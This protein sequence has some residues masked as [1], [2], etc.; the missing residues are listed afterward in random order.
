MYPDPAGHSTI[1]RA[2]RPVALLGFCAWPERSYAELEICRTRFLPRGDQVVSLGSIRW[3]ATLACNDPSD[4]ISLVNICEYDEASIH[5]YTLIC[6]DIHW[7]TLIY[8]VT[9]WTSKKVTWWL[10]WSCEAPSLTKAPVQGIH[11][12]LH[13]AH[14]NSSERPQS[15]T[16][17]AMVWSAPAG[18]CP[19]VISW[20]ITPINYSYICHKP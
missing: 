2:P 8:I 13:A 12:N 17:N 3:V 15:F 10:R 16:G 19:P 6:I 4:P 1:G 18:W 11:R 20:F 5:W 7:Y 9:L 14:W